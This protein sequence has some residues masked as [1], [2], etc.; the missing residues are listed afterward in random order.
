MGEWNSYINGFGTP[1]HETTLHVGSDSCRV[2]YTRAV[3]PYLDPDS[4]GSLDPY[5]NLDSQKSYR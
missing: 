1:P 3:D 5:L 4:M 2:S